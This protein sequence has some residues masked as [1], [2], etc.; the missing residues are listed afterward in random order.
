MSWIKHER[1]RKAQHEAEEADDRVADPSREQV[2][3]YAIFENI[4]GHSCL[5]VLTPDAD[6]IQAED[7][8]QSSDECDHAHHNLRILLFVGGH[9]LYRQDN[10]NSLISIYR[11]T[12]RLGPVLRDSRHAAADSLAT[13]IASHQFI[14]AFE[15]DK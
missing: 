5:N 12:N 9:L 14:T 6:A 10:A 8:V 3:V 7:A 13:P 1:I 11:K 15:H 2:E 4:S